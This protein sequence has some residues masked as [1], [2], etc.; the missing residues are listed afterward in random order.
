MKSNHLH[1]RLYHLADT[2]VYLMDFCFA[3]ECWSCNNLVLLVHMNFFWE[4]KGKNYLQ[5][6]LS[7]KFNYHYLLLR[8][9]A[10]PSVFSTIYTSDTALYSEFGCYVGYFRT[11]FCLI[12]TIETRVLFFT[13][14]LQVGFSRS[15]IYLCLFH[16]WLV[17][18]VLVSL[19]RWLLSDFVVFHCYVADKRIQHLNEFYVEF[20]CALS[21]R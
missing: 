21:L 10:V 18:L 5:Y 14:H 11:L 12:G 17:T 9:L 19:L 8:Y 13:I 15:L 4:V 20:N 7:F 3:H 1:D 6:R 16:K 2:I